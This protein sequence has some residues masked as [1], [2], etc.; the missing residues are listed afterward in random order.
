LSTNV[1]VAGG[2]GALGRQLVKMLRDCERCSQSL[3][4]RPGGGKYWV[5]VDLTTAAGLAEAVEGVTVGFVY[6]H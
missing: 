2:T 1:L 5:Q 4:Q 6:S 3:S